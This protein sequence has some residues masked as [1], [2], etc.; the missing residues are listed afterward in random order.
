MVKDI[1]KFENLWEVMFV[2][3]FVRGDVLDRAVK[4]IKNALKKIP[5][6]QRAYVISLALQELEEEERT[7][8]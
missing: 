5:P 2:T 7:K 4:E 8:Y 1:V 3:M 6:S